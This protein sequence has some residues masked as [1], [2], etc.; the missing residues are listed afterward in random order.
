MIILKSILVLIHF[1]IIDYK[2]I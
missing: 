2:F 1:T